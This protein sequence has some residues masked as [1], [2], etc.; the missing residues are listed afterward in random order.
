M[1]RGFGISPLYPNERPHVAV[2][3]A[4]SLDGKIS[5]YRR[6]EI[7]LGTEHDRRLMDVLRAD[8]D[9]VIVGS[10]T[11]R[12]DGFPIRIRYSDL[13]AER[14]AHGR[15]PHPVNVT[16]SR[17]LNVPST[18][19]FFRHPDTERIVFTTRAAPATRVKLISRFAEVITLRSRT[20]SPTAVLAELS[21][22]GM[23]RVLLEGG[24]EL[25]FAFA[26]EGVIDDLYITL[27]PRLIGGVTSPTVL[28]GKG[29][30]A[31]DHIDLRLVTRKQIGDE[32][33][34]KYSVVR[35]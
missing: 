15:T 14:V 3:M 31:A 20:I 6:E 4:M 33:F 19:P 30:L 11:V 22:R 21:R 34:L 1:Q 23:R 13:E 7:S 28:D 27:T 24:G 12:H 17:K 5:T 2:N 32:L 18:R 35:D 8:A 26:R 29:F 25:H 10:G 9:A 16:M